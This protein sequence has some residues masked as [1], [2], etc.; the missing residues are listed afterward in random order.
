MQQHGPVDER[1][2]AFG[3]DLRAVLSSASPS[4]EAERRLGRR[5][6]IVDSSHGIPLEPA[7]WC[8]VTLAAAGPVLFASKR[9][10]PGVTLQR[11][12]QRRWDAVQLNVRHCAA[13]AATT[14]TTTTTTVPMC[15][16]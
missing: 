9:E 8:L 15:C 2:G 6:R 5:C 12:L 11:L 7:T 14:T 16:C 13:A 4:A 1:A 3:L 10:L